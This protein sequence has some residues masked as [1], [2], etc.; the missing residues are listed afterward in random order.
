MHSQITRQ[1]TIV[2]LLVRVQRRLWL[3]RAMHDLALAACVLSAAWLGLR[4]LALLRHTPPAFDRFMLPVVVVCL[5]AAI[6][7]L[8]RSR[9]R[10]TLERTACVVDHSAGLA[11]ELKT[12]CW[13]LQQTQPSAMALRQIE[14]ARATA[15]A[16]EPARIVPLR[17]PAA[18]GVAVTLLF[19]GI[20]VP[21]V[22]TDS[23]RRAPD[24][25][26]AAS[27]TLPEASPRPAAERDRTGSEPVA[28]S[29]GAGPDGP[30]ND[31]LESRDSE[32]GATLLPPI[33]HRIASAP[34]ETDSAGAPAAAGS[35]QPPAPVRADDTDRP[36]PVA[37]IKTDGAELTRV[38]RI[39][40]HRAEQA[41]KQP[42]G[43]VA[44]VRSQAPRMAPGA[45]PSAQPAADR[46]G[47]AGRSS[48]RGAT[49]GSAG[50]PAAGNADAAKDASEPW[51]P[52]P[53]GE[54][55]LGELTARLRAELER[56]HI[57]RISGP[58]STAGHDVVFAPTP[59]QASRL[60]YAPASETVRYTGEAP[61]RHEEVP[62]AYREAVKRYFLG[63]NARDR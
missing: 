12:A 29:L 46:R 20:A 48:P 56:L 27:A 60:E 36:P 57:D 30:G 18:A 13:L 21:T 41:G 7:Q 53:G 34:L 40:Q 15:S 47:D 9:A 32:G 35:A 28:E 2:A 59:F 6:V 31:A 61:A 50:N 52:Q 11:D 5:I 3:D 14:R 44:D 58:G 38:A 19:A 1:D 26:A 8:A 4:A 37:V 23:S 45:D 54:P 43:E 25:T 10:P 42:Q 55:L 63:V 24:A 22:S 51:R 16:L 17:F 39:A 62:A 33:Q 49:G